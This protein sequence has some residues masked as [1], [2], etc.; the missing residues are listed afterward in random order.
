MP[1]I[2]FQEARAR[3][4]LAA[5]LDLLGFVP[6]ARYGDQLRGPCPVHRSQS[7]TSR[8]FA[9]H[10]GKGVWHCFTC[11][12]GGNTLDLWARVTHQGIHA[13]V[14]DLCRRLGWD[15]PWSADRG[16][17][18]TR[19]AACARRVLGQEKTMHDP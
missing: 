3:L 8:S 18:N 10:L 15:V 6:R 9:A 5:V 17:A 11:N 19:R 16:L 14:L 13:A 4:R 2:D 7:A 1:G 12:A